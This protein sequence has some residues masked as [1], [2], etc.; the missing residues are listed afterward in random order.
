MIYTLEPVAH[1]AGGRAERFEDHWRDV[2]AVI[3][4]ADHVPADATLGL[5]DFSHLEVVFV[6]DRIDPATIDPAA[7]HSRGNPAY[8]VVGMFA[9]HR[10]HRLNRLGVSR[11]RLLRVEGRDLHVADLDAL[12]GI[13]VLD[14]KPYMR[15]FAPQTPV[16]QPGWSSD[17][18]R[19]YYRPVTEGPAGP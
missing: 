8:P 19:D 4:I 2:T 14:I 18:M 5:S 13:P 3:R 10:P 7:A 9:T 15:E 1:V 11:C 12:D 17:L 6:F 16:R